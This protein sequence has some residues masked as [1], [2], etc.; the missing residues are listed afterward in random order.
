MQLWGERYNTRMGDIFAVQEDIA[1]D[2]SRGLRLKLAPKDETLRPRRHTVNPE[3]YR[4]YLLSRHELNK[5]PTEGFKKALEFARQATETDSTYAPAYT[6]LADSYQWLGQVGQLPYREAFSRA[7]AAAMR[8]LEID[9]TLPEAHTAL[10]AA[11]RD[12]DWDWAEAER[13][14]RRAME[15]D[16]NSADAHQGYGNYQTNFGSLR[17]GIAEL[18][19]AVELDPLSPPRHVGL[20]FAY[21]FARQYDQA[22]E[23]VRKA[24]ELDPDL[25][26]PLTHFLLGWIHRE[27]GM[28]EKAIDEFEK[29]GNSVHILGHLGNAFARADRVTEAR[30]CIRELKKRLAEESVGSYE[31]GLV[32]AGLGEK[33]LAFESGTGLRRA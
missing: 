32:Y 22:L 14:F 5:G 7:K 31:V 20:F 28:Y 13:G 2:I 18:K 33:D 17:E 15:L 24:M 4:L 3:A 25:D 8:A 23:P 27:K 29:A 11:V 16:P 26:P 21:Y 1:R 12:L 19:P 10:A 30:D 9:E 6:T